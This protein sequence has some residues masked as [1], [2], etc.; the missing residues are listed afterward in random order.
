[1][2]DYI[3]IDLET[4]NSKRVSACALGFVKVIN[5]E[6]VETKSFLIKP[7]GGHAPL[8]SKI[9]GITADDTDDK[10]DFGELYQEIKDIKSIFNSVLSVP[11]TISILEKFH[12]LLVIYLLDSFPIIF[13]PFACFN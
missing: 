5:N 10:S 3:C 2:K 7:V 11:N 1:M 9:H 8:Q 6:I 4:G 12:I 13:K